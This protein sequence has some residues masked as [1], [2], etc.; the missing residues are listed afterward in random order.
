MP[1]VTEW[2]GETYK[3]IEPHPE[4]TAYLA[5]VNDLQAQV[6]QTGLQSPEAQLILE[7]LREQSI[8]MVNTNPFQSVNK[9]GTLERIK[10]DLREQVNMTSA[11]EAFETF[12]TVEYLTEAGWPQS[13]EFFNDAVRP[14]IETNLLAPH[15]RKRFPH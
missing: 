6:A 1:E 15:W 4:T 8:T 3:G 7:D 11:Q 2:Y 14:K 9:S 5:T 12:W 13:I 10:E